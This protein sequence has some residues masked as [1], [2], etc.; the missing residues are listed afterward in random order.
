MRRALKDSNWSEDFDKNMESKSIEDI[1][2]ELKTKIIELRDKHIP[3]RKAAANPT[4]SKKSSI[5]LSN[6]TIDAIK[7]KKKTHRQWME[8]KDKNSSDEAYIKYKKARNKVKTY[9][10]RDK[11]CFE[12]S[13][14]IDAKRNPKRFWYHA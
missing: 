7:M 11:K 10:R 5:P 14:A 8:K 4:W 3:L 1:W 12:K 2:L 13:I 9:L 6:T